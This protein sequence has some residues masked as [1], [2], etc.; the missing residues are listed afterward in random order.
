MGEHGRRRIALLEIKVEQ[1]LEFRMQAVFHTPRSP[2][3]L[4]DDYK[5]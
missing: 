2:A 3:W 1:Q 5:A 4:A